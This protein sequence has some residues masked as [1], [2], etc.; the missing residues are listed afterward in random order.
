MEAT[1]GATAEDGVQLG[2]NIGPGSKYVR[3]QKNMQPR[4]QQSEK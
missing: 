3:R 2:E 1:I 4:P